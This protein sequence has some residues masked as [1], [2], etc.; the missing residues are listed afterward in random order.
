MNF[1]SFET[2]FRDAA[3]T[4]KEAGILPMDA[5]L[6]GLTVEPPRDASLAISRQRG[7]G[8]GEAGEDAAAGSCGAFHR[9][10]EAILTSKAGHSRSGVHQHDAE[11][12]LLAGSPSTS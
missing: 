9:R 6:S 8:A 7:D 4:L 11:A 3:Q 2:R 12:G 10:L 5:D 1:C